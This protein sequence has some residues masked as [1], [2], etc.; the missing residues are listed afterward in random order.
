ML[1]AAVSRGAPKR[2]AATAP[3]E[4]LPLIERA[5]QA[6]Q[7]A[8]AALYRRHLPAVKRKLAAIVGADPELDDLI[9]QTFVRAFRQLDGFRGEARLSTWLQRIAINVALTHLASLRRRRWL[10]RPLE[11]LGR[12]VADHRPSP[13]EL[14]EHSERLAALYGVLSRLKPANL[15]VFVLFEIEQHTID[16]IAEL[17]GL[18]RNTV[19]ARLRRTRAAVTR[20]LRRM[21]LRWTRELCHDPPAGTEGQP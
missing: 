8:M 19:A 5:R 11:L 14:V 21:D 17:L 20:S 6:D 18:S 3:D 10:L 13:A 9:Q 4:D 7:R 1:S 12:P 16:E 15:V 2:S